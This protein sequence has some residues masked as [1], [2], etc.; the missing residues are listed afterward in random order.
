MPVARFC[1]LAEVLCHPVHTSGLIIPFMRL[2]PAPVL[3]TPTGTRP[4]LRANARVPLPHTGLA[5]GEQDPLEQRGKWY[6]MAQDK[7]GPHQGSLLHKY[8]FAPF[9]R[10]LSLQASDLGVSGSPGEYR[11]WGPGTRRAGC[12]RAAQRPAP[13]G[14]EAAPQSLPSSAKQPRLR[15]L[16]GHIQPQKNPGHVHGRQLLMLLW[17]SQS[18]C[19][20]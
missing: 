12:P 9:P 2:L 1:H 8:L 14:A 16:V 4:H 18:P 6:E 13:S 11:P 15:I 3:K 5:Q 7:G 20:G 19:V 17:G 10:P